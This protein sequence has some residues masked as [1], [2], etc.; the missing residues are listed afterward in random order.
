MKVKDARKDGLQQTALIFIFNF[1]QGLF[2]T[3]SIEKQF[4]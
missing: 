4:T 2:D 3:L 1:H